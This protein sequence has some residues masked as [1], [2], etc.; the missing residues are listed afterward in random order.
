[1]RKRERLERAIAGEPVDRPP[2]AL[3]RHFPGDD[4][5]ALDFARAT[6][7]FQAQFDW[8][9]IKFCPPSSYCTADFGLQD[10]WEGAADGTRVVRRRPI[11]RPVDW[12]N[13]RPLD[14]RRGE[15]GRHFEALERILKVT[16]EDTPVLATVFSP[17]GQA[18]NLAGEEALRLH[19]RTEPERLRTGLNILTENVLRIVEELRQLPIAGVFYAIR[20]ASY[21]QLSEDE[22]TSFG[23]PDDEK[24]LEALPRN[25]WFNMVHLH[26]EHPMFRLV[27]RLRCHAINWHDRET[28]PD[29][30]MGKAL[31]DGAVCGG[32]ARSEHLLLGTPALIRDT[33]RDAIRGTGGRR[34]IIGTGCVTSITTPLS[35][36][37]AV[38]EAVE[39][40]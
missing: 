38:R 7:D 31:F 6:L 21:T 15:L 40:P 37:R 13:L 25:C 8:D 29:L 26:G 24:I 9:F 22:Y 20:H 23:L 10:V 2:V 32:L 39:S 16:G 28:E 1:M 35:N 30:T 14:P 4:Q 12:T 34:L 18:R 11:A 17:L 36:L 3:W 19:L 27:S 5:R 33:V